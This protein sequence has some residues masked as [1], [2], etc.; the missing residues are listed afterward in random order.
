MWLRAILSSSLTVVTGAIWSA[1]INYF[2]FKFRCKCTDTAKYVVIFE[3]P[4]KPITPIKLIPKGRVKAPQGSRYTSF[5]QLE[6]ATNLDE[7][8]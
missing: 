3:E 6:K 2:W 8:F 7:A 4:A 5:E 1:N